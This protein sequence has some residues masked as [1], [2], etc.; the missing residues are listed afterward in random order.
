MLVKVRKLIL[1]VLSIILLGR[2]F[3][4]GSVLAQGKDDLVTC[5][6]EVKQIREKEGEKW[7]T[8]NKT[9]CLGEE[10]IGEWSVLKLADFDKKEV[11]ND[12]ELEFFAFFDVPVAG[13]E[14]RKGQ[15]EYQ[16]TSKPESSAPGYKREK[17][18]EDPGIGDQSQ[19]QIETTDLDIAF[20]YDN[21][22][23]VWV[24]NVVYQ[25]L[26]VVVGDC[27]FM[28][29]GRAGRSDSWSF[30]HHVDWKNDVV[31]NSDHD[32]GEGVVK[33]RMREYARGLVG[34]ISGVCTSQVSSPQPKRETTR[35][36]FDRVFGPL[37]KQQ[38]E[39]EKK[40]EE[41]S[42]AKAN[43]VNEWILETFGTPSVE[44]PE[45]LKQI[46]W[47]EPGEATRL[48]EGRFFPVGAKQEYVFS[49]FLDRPITSGKE[50]IEVPGNTDLKISSWGSGSGAAVKA[51]DWE[52]IEFVAPVE[53][54][55]FTTRAIELRDGGVEI[56]VINKSPEK[57]K[58]KVEITD[59]LDA[60]SIETHYFVSYS[61]ET[62]QALIIVYEGKVEIKTK[63]GQTVRVKPE[64]DKPGMVVISQKLSPI[65]LAALGL[66]LVG[67]IGA[68]LFISGKRFVSKKSRKK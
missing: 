47:L 57:N 5:I 3:L 32:H 42:R 22:S 33:E 17:K 4:P 43:A 58:F 1:P 48:Q 67:I 24:S 2:L 68:A 18:V 10:V 26:M 55:G 15:M 65:K 20:G 54:G 41:E 31:I 46:G 35:E 30:N 8:K 66:G 23:P 40:P 13:A 61:P 39:D 50:I 64:G 21:F 53:V 7:Y 62:K 59:F 14:V 38:E 28:V 63:D 29:G 44:V 16:K 45:D 36:W 11:Y 25:E 6:E 27:S 56:K 37:L 34:R 51:M 52:K 60:V 12:M 9:S 19:H 49:T